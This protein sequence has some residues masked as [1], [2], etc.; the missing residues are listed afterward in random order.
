MT[1]APNLHELIET[2]LSDAGSTDP[3]ELLGRAAR[4]AGEL[5]EVTDALLGHFVDRSRRAGRSWSEISSVL[6]VSKQAAHK[7]FWATPSRDAEGKP[8][9][10]RFTPRAKAV[11][12]DAGKQAR[13]LRRPAVGSEDIL[14]ALFEPAE[15]I[16]AQVLQ[17]AGI[18][19][20]A[21]LARIPPG[22]EGA[23]APAE[24]AMPY[25]QPAIDVLR[26]ALQE[27]L[28][29]GHNYIG[30]EHLLLG[31][32]DDGAAVAG[33]SAILVAAGAG[34]PDIKERVSAKLANFRP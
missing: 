24:G 21:V 28:Q 17:E 7:R 31:L 20:D 19:R 29:L 1:P 22:S 23:T 13:T 3:L 9:F 27:A 32:F 15:A 10:E 33:G 2:V 34:Y 25:S 4:T 18:D 12:A 11:L 30:T 16:A 8:T 5:E 14:L 6:G 26:R